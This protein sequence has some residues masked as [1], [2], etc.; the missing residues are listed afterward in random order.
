MTKLNL[1]YFF[2]VAAIS[3]FTIGCV[4]P[5]PVPQWNSTSDALEAEYN[6][7]LIQGNSTLA[8]QAFL[9]QQNGGVV[10]AAGRTVT[11]D[12]STSVGNEWWGKAGKTY[13][14]RTLT[15]SSP[16]FHKARKT[17][18]ADADGKFK[19][20]NLAPGKYYVCTEVTW[21][22]GGY[23]PTQ[24]G[25]VGQLVEIKDGQAAEVV[26]NQYPQ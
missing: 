5:I 18:I 8:G 24:G 2:V 11:L 20:S 4:Q 10:K 15:P 16:N 21:E 17:V 26:L 6:P 23:F 7:Y 12:P 22:V 3:I 14:H 1:Q 19:F 13:V 25:R 9:T